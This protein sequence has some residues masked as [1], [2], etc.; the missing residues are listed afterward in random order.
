[1]KVHNLTGD[2]IIE[3][4]AE[5]LA[6]ALRVAVL[7]DVSFREADLSD[8]YLR[9]AYLHGADLRHAN[10][11]GAD[12]RVADLR[13]AGLRNADLRSADLHGADLRDADL[14][15]ADLRGA[16][17]RGAHLNGANLHDADLRHANLRVANLRGVDLD[18]TKLNDANFGDVDLDDAD[19]L[20]VR[21]DLW[22]VLDQAKTEVPP[23]LDAV[24]K[25][26]VDGSVYEGDCACLLGT[27]A[28]A[29]G[30]PYASLGIAPDA[31]RPAE[32]FFTHIRPGHVPGLSEYAALAETW[33][34]MWQERQ[35]ETARQGDT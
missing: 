23:L 30:C 28:N 12:L 9:G 14:R 13:G 21:E 6:A 17:L 4:E 1:M 16:N 22:K 5:T 10:L 27:I 26:R 29:R 2:L 31:G 18:S 8:M 35:R 24:R 7:R 34:M 20:R 25:G 33:I 3:I 15:G 11:S 19:L 32:R